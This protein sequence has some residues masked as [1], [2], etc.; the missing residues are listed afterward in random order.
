MFLLVDL[1]NKSDEETVLIPRVGKLKQEFRSM[2][3]SAHAPI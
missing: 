2:L 1:I 3:N